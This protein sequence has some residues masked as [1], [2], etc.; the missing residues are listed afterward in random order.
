MTLGGVALVAVAGMAAPLYASDTATSYADGAFRKLGRGVANIV[1]CPLELIRTPELVGRKDGYV[2]AMSTG[3]AQGAWH[4]VVRGLAGVWD[5]VT[6]YAA[7]PE[8]F[9]P[10]VTPEFIYAHGD[11]AE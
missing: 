11:W 3:L 6:F 2:A 1:T 5:V 10:L 4:T 7:I 9:R 8:G